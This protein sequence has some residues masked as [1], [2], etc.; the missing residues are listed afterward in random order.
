[1]SEASYRA[2]GVAMAIAGVVCFSLRPIF[3]KL[4]Y[5]IVVDPITLLALGRGLAD[6]FRRWGRV[7]LA[8]STLRRLV[9]EPPAPREVAAGGIPFA[10][11]LAFGLAAQWLEGSPW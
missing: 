5:G 6:F 4:A 1:V 3:I 11:A 10:A 2:I 9:Y 7:L 8:T